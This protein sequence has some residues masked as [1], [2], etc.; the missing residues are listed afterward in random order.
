MVTG[1]SLYSRTVPGDLDFDID[2]LTARTEGQTLEP[3]EVLPL[4]DADPDFVDSSTLHV[5]KRGFE[6]DDA[7]M[8]LWQSELM[9]DSWLL[10]VRDPEHTLVS[11]ITLLMPHP[12]DG[13]P[14][15]GA[16]LLRTEGDLDA[17]GAPVLATLETKLAGRGWRTLSVSPMIDQERRISWWKS[18]GYRPLDVRPDNN[19][20]EVLRL[21]KSL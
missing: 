19:R 12:D 6:V 18:A 1:G 4:L 14:W 3:E 8:F 16:L 13:Q 5:G 10:A 17:V 7:A 2:G 20:R 21:R 9:Q 11:V 15:I